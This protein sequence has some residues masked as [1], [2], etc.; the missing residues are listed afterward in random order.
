[1]LEKFAQYH[2]ETK[3]TVVGV[4]MGFEITL[5]RATVKGNVDRIE[6]DSDGK[7][8]IIDFKTGKNAISQ[9]DAD[10]NLQLACYQL[11]VILEG[12]K[13]KLT[14]NQVSG[15]ELVYVATD[16]QKASTRTRAPIDPA[17]VQETIELIADQM[18]KSHFTARK[19]DMCARC[20][21]KP[22]CPL[23]LEGKAVHE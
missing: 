2:R 23:H 11:G 3:R 7:Y 15:S 6:V 18:S 8:Y 21:V 17:N 16:A 9:N 4:E 12:F 1:M 13:D 22:V 10:E 14:G 20:K 5:G 19:N